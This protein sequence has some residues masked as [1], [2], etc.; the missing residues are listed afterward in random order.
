[1][2][3]SQIHRYKAA[4][5][6]FW[7]LVWKVFVGISVVVT[8]ASSVSNFEYL[9]SH[10][11]RAGIFISGLTIFISLLLL[12]N[13]LINEGLKDKAPL[14]LSVEVVNIVTTLYGEAKYLDV[15]RFGST[16]S[17]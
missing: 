6:H 7:G 5:I 9:K 12:I 1:M 3:A 2:S 10:P 8:V 17:R 11:L 15:V 13:K 4:A 14:I 16:I